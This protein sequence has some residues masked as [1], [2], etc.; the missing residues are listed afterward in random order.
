MARPRGG[1]WLAD[2]LGSLWHVGVDVLVCALT[3]P[4]L[5]ELGLT[6]EAAASHTA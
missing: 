6:A 2:E 3:D 5:R 1:E 4:E